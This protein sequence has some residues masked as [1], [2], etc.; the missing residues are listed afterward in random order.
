MNT[1]DSPRQIVHLVDDDESV[2]SSLGR[3]LRASGFETRAYESSA[4]FLLARS[5]TLRGCVI[6]DVRMPGGPGGLELHEGLLRQKEHL[7]VI[8]LTGHGDIPMSVRAMK[9]GAFDFLTKPAPAKLLVE[10]V[11]AALELESSNWHAGTRRREVAARIA[12]LTRAEYEVYKRVVAGLPNK[13][14]MGEIGCAER[15]V[16]AHRSSMMTKMGV[17]SVAELVHL[18]DDL[19]LA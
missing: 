13:R 5:G 18:S 11:K 16:K 17:S 10:T 14:I 9:S 15:T 1:T 4:Q 19:I 12:S 2:R 6:M 3:L 7:P 8:F